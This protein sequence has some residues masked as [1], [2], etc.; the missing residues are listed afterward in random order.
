[1]AFFDALV[2]EEES[3]SSDLST[4]PEYVVEDCYSSDDSP[5]LPRRAGQNPCPFNFMQYPY[6]DEERGRATWYVTT[7]HERWDRHHGIREWYYGDD[8]EGDEEGAWSDEEEDREERLRERENSPIASGGTT[9][10]RGKQEV[11]NE[12]DGER[13]GTDRQP[14]GNNNRSQKED[15]DFTARSKNHSEKSE[16]KSHDECGSA[17]K[18]DLLLPHTQETE[19]HSKLTAT[20][21][22][23]INNI[24]TQSSPDRRE[25]PL[26][27]VDT[28]KQF[29]PRKF[30]SSSWKNLPSKV[31][32]PLQHHISLSSALDG[33][34]TNVLGDS[35]VKKVFLQ[36]GTGTGPSTSLNGDETVSKGT[37]DSNVEQA[38]SSMSRAKRREK[39]LCSQ[40]TVMN[41][42]SDPNQDLASISAATD[43]AACISGVSG[44]QLM[45]CNKKDKS[46]S[47]KGKRPNKELHY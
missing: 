16:P 32:P 18:L 13:V 23:S 4:T 40:G 3:R 30:Y 6:P 25:T 46:T 34:T 22:C 27:E 20:S 8:D 36:G 24:A 10:D 41:G 5:P 33:V 45:V 12:A 1:M 39:R 19:N 7:P 42:P 14:S 29:P 47:W 26:Q 15:H 43:T 28:H 17:N 38:D 2:N 37:V 44:N 9:N 35:D 11:V 21:S 31:T